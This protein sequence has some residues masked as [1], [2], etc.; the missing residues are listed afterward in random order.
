MPRSI[1]IPSPHPNSQ[2]TPTKASIYQFDIKLRKKKKEINLFTLESVGLL[3]RGT[4]LESLELDWRSE[5][6]LSSESIKRIQF[7]YKK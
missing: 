1:P 3:K 5:S 2:I 6:L 7:T 4:M